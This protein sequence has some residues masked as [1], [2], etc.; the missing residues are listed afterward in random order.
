MS[1]S[2]YV[3][4]L[5][6][7][8]DFRAAMCTFL[9]EVREAMVSY[10]LEVRRTL[11]WLLEAQ[12]KRW[13]QE[14]RNCEEAASKARIELERCRASSLPGGGTPSCME[15]RKSLERSRARLQYAHDKLESV[16]KW[17]YVLGREADEYT[18]RAHQ[19]AGLFDAELPQAIA[20]LDR[21]L[22]ALESY[23]ALEA[24]APATASAAAA[25]EPVA[26]PLDITATAGHEDA[27]QAAETETKVLDESRPPVQLADDG[28]TTENQAP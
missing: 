18:G 20:T 17:G 9:A 6:A 2:A 12:P 7:V 5:E 26:R 16:R 21:I 3:G 15:E 1:Q 24:P 10:D 25:L 14:V 4:S 13:H 28:S 22:S 11:D 23:A 8:R 19:L 27:R